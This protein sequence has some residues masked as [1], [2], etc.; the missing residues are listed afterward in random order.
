MAS[1]SC[2]P[3]A[4]PYPS[5]PGMPFGVACAEA[6]QSSSVRLCCKGAFE[7]DEARSQGRLCRRDREP[8]AA[9]AIDRQFPG[10]A[11]PAVRKA[12]DHRDPARASVPDCS[13]AWT[14]RVLV[15]M[16]GDTSTVLERA[17]P[18]PGTRHSYPTA[19]TGSG[20]RSGPAASCNSSAQP[21]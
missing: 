12:T 1:V 3:Q 17:T 13:G 4:T 8:A 2:R 5:L 19:L 14:R 11:R 18:K 6:W 20:P 7:T 9:M 21:G 10:L 16:K 15:G